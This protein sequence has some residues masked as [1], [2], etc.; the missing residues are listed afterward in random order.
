MRGK[1]IILY[2]NPR[3]GNIITETNRFILQDKVTNN[4]YI[5]TNN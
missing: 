4:L 3:H 1:Y 5:Y 2:Y